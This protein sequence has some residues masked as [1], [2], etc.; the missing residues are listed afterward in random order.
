MSLYLLI[1]FLILQLTLQALQ[2]LPP[3]TQNYLIKTE[4]GYQLV[5]LGPGTGTAT[6]IAATNHANATSTLRLQSFPAVSKCNPKFH[7]KSSQFL[8]IC[9]FLKILYRVQNPNHLFIIN[10]AIHLDGFLFHS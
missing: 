10:F 4:N 5:R 3:G 6:A 1:I 7:Y 9:E 8:L 2:S